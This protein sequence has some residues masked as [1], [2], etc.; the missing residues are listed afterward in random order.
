VN[1][2]PPGTPHPGLCASC[3][4]RRWISNRRGSSFLLCEKSAEDPRFPKYPPLPVRACAGYER[5]GEPGEGE[6][7]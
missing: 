6:A 7:P 5:E 3:R 2:V 1:E 4:H